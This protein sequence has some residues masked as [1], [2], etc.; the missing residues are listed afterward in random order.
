MPKRIISVCV[1][2]Y[3]KNKQRGGKVIMLIALIMKSPLL[4]VS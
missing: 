2:L 3:E 1:P 4:T